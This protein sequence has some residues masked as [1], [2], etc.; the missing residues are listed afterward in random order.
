MGTKV[1]TG[2]ENRLAHV[3]GVCLIFMAHAV[4]FYS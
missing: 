2:R 3:G 4:S 1:K